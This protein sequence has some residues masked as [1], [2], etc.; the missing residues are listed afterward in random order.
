[1]NQLMQRGRY[2]AIGMTLVV[3]LVLAACGGDATA[4]PTPTDVH[5]PH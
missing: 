1:M 2:E 5:H 3:M 4:T